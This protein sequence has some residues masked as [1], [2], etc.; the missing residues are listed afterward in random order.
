MTISEATLDLDL[1]WYWRSLRIPPPL[2]VSTWAQKYRRLSP[3]SSA[4]PGR[5]SNDRAPYQTG[6][7]DAVND[8]RYEMVVWMSSSQVGKTEGG[9]LNMLGYHMD[10]DPCPILIVLP[11]IEDCRVFSKTRLMP[12]I[13]D[14]PQL[15]G[16]IRETRGHTAIMAG[17]SNELLHKTFPGGH[18]TM[19]GSNSASGLASRPIRV[20]CMDEI[21]RFEP[22][23]GSEGDQ[24]QLAKR[25][26]ITYWNRKM[27][28]TSTPGLKRV[29]RIE[30][31]YEQSDRRRYH[32][33]CPFCGE[34]QVLDFGQLK[35]DKDPKTGDHL[36][37]TAYF[38]CLECDERIG[39]NHKAWMLANGT[40]LA[41]NPEVNIA[42]FH[43]W[44]AYSPWMRWSSIAEEF[45]K[46]KHGGREMLMTFINTILGQSWE[47]EGES[48]DYE[49]LTKRVES[50]QLGTVPVGVLFLTAGAD[51]QNDR[52][53]IS[54]WGWGSSEEVW[55]V[56][57]QV[58]YGDPEQD[59]TWE[60]IDAYLTGSWLQPST[61]RG[62]MLTIVAID[63]AFKTQTVYSYVRRQPLAYA[64]RGSS[65]PTA[66]RIGHPAWHDIDHRG[67]VLKHGLQ[68]W[69]IGTNSLKATIYS[70][71]KL[72]DHGPRAIHFPSGLEEE[73]F[74]QLTAERLVN[75][76]NKGH[77]RQEWHKI[78]P[79]NEA[80]DCF[81]YAYAAAL[82]AGMERVAWPSATSARPAASTP[83]RPTTP[84][85]PPPGT[86]SPQAATPRPGFAQPQRRRGMRGGTGG[87]L[88]RLL[89]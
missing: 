30:F 57:H 87:T 71:L 86:N 21:D 50:Y 51:V 54:V 89:G 11:N 18:L 28:L 41:A 63:T 56:D 10:Y 8:P 37:E 26:T 36:F 65:T 62:M 66:P 33:P 27:I 79:R 5:W 7:M 15:R 59:V 82:I 58:F 47:E 69:L 20:V 3:E 53:E 46:A 35:W 34:R 74:Q 80:L 12:M 22:S 77:L 60:G 44:A 84:A 25:R 39:E 19:V 73:W 61:A 4:E 32:V 68:V 23:A 76:Y 45:V 29:S 42:G 83:T 14:T 55:L 38:E 52:V 2:T 6:F 70:R 31:W 16:K 48:P 81:V 43:I 78:R 17:S 40:W 9:V 1:S 13:R 75:T 64:V 72:T 88:R 24:I 67:T 49:I 85:G